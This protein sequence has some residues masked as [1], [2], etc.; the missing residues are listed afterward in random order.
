MAFK[1]KM[2]RRDATCSAEDTF[3]CHTGAQRVA[4]GLF[5]WQHEVGVGWKD[6]GDMEKKTAVSLHIDEN[7]KNNKNIFEHLFLD[8]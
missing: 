5:V 2:L 1:A 7:I 6:N 8:F 3:V 4:K